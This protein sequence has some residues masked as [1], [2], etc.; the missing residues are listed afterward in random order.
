[1]RSRFKDFLIYGN[2]SVCNEVNMWLEQNPYTRIVRWSAAPGIDHSIR[3]IIEFEDL[4]SSSQ[5][6]SANG[7]GS[8]NIDT[9]S[10]WGDR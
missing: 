9:T 8:Y 5:Y 3:L 6:A 10:D 2:K 4:S 1:M 7:A